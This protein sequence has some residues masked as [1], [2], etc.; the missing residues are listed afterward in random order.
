M[1]EEMPRNVEDVFLV[2]KKK[3]LYS[4]GTLLPNYFIIYL[5]STYYV[6]V[7]LVSVRVTARNISSLL[8][9]IFHFKNSEGTRIRGKGTF[10]W[11]L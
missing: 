6:P 10:D 9:L 7:T 3:S 8:L 11:R 2:G 5:V 4:L 1:F